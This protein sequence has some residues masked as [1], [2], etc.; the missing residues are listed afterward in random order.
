MQSS[1]WVLSIILEANQACKMTLSLDESLQPASQMTALL[2]ARDLFKTEVLQDK[3]N[4]RFMFDEHNPT[5]EDEIV[6]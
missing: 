2:F 6:S 4:T 5:V 1:K 3:I